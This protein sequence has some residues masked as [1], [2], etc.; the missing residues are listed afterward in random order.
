MQARMQA[1][2]RASQRDGWGARRVD[3]KRVVGSAKDRVRELEKH[4]GGYK[5]V[6]RTGQTPFLLVC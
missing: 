2:I 6:T 4:I 3:T 5:E 1:W